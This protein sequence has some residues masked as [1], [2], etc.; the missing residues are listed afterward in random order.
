MY[1]EK[2]E[3]Q[4][5]SASI[6]DTLFASVHFKCVLKEGRHL[7]YHPISI[8]RLRAFNIR[9]LHCQDL[10]YCPNPFPNMPRLPLSYCPPLKFQVSKPT[11][12]PQRRPSPGPCQSPSHP[13]PLPTATATS[14]TITRLPPLDQ[15][16]TTFPSHTSTRTKSRSSHH[17]VTRSCLRKEDGRLI[18]V[19][20]Y[21]LVESAVSA[22]GVDFNGR[23]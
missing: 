8:R 1:F 14:T 4:S 16:S 23:V 11:P 7:S 2:V 15:R 17:G 18:G 3:F 20:V 12:S 19:F 13:H 9:S 22:V 21:R 5:Y 6:V 10:A